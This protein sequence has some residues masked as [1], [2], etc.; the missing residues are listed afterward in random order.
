MI[1]AEVWALFRLVVFVSDSGAVRTPTVHNDWKIFI[2]YINYYF[3]QAVRV[4]Y[5]VTSEF[6]NCTKL[7]TCKLQVVTTIG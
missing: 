7:A 2:N 4:A 6:L 5:F 3:S 1:V